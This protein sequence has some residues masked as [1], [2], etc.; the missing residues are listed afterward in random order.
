LHL[1]RCTIP[2][3]PLR[4]SIGPDRHLTRPEVSQISYISMGTLETRYSGCVSNN[5]DAQNDIWRVQ[6]C[7][8]QPC[9]PGHC[10]VKRVLLQVCTTASNRTVTAQCRRRAASLTLAW[11]PKHRTGA[12]S[13][14]RELLNIAVWTPTQPRAFSRVRGSRIATRCAVSELVCRV[15]WR[16]GISSKHGRPRWYCFNSKLLGW[17]PTDTFT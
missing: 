1:T 13:P 2:V 15:V 3:S 7:L 11:T 14:R 12:L 9:L 6:I 5:C 4:T 8:L 10:D 17:E 16:V